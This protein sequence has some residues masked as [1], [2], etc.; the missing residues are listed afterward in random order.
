MLSLISGFFQKA[1]LL[2]K[3][4]E[5]VKVVQ[6]CIAVVIAMWSRIIWV[7]L[8]RCIQHTKGLSAANT[9]SSFSNDLC[10]YE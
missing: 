3:K 1:V 10:A 4:M 8:Y 2:F 9:S 7:R 5:E 6:D